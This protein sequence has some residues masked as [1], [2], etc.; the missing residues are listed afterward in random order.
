V[1]TD[2][3]NV[4][5]AAPNALQDFTSCPDWGMGGQFTYDPVTKTRTRIVAE[6]ASVDAP[7]VAEAA[8]A[9]DAGPTTKARKGSAN[10]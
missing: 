8:A 4:Q 5:A 3:A 1:S 7:A 9:A 6:P 2:N 10:A